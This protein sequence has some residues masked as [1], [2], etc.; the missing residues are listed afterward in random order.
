LLLAN[1]G[2]P[3]ILWVVLIVGGVI[4]VGFTYLFGLENNTVHT[5]VVASLA[6]II[7]LTLFTV[8]ALDHPF[9]GDII[10]HSDAFEQVLDRFE[11]SSLSDL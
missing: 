9:R 4:V 8:A 10:V 11:S 7:S 2:L 1:E 3:T 6:L 5:L